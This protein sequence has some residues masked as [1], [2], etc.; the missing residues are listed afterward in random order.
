MRVGGGALARR[1]VEAQLELTHEQAGHVLPSAGHRQS[2][3]SLRRCGAN[4]DVNVGR[5]SRHL[6]CPGRGLSSGHNAVTSLIRA[7][8]QSDHS[9]EME[10]PDLIA[11]TDPRPAD[12][13]TSAF[14]NAYTALDISIFSPHAQRPGSDCTHSS[15]AVK[16]DC[17][18][19]HLSPPTPS[20]RLLHPDCL[21]C[22]WTTPTM[23]R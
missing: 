15:L 6:L 5:C 14:G 19:P 7:A 2:Q 4:A 12:V 1:H 16:S 22:P 10:V 13:L 11:G 17:C 23:T 8:A 3:R 20:E 21:E 18:G 9:A